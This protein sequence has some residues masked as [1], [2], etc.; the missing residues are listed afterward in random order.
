MDIQSEKYSLIEYVTQ[1]K[2]MAVVEKLKQ[3]VKATELDFWDELTESQR[4]EIK[5]GM[6]ELDRGEKVDY[7]EVMARHRQ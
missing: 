1:I 7:E 6:N 3:F 2:D 5:R 4:Q